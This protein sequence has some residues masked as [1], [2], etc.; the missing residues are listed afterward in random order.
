MLE[1]LVAA[2]LGIVVGV[3]YNAE[4]DKV[5]DHYI[6]KWPRRTVGLAALA[7]IVVLAVL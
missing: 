5:L 7:A 6:G 3:L 4:L 1:L 2:A